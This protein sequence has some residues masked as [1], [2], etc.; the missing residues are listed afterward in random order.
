[1]AQ[2]LNLEVSFNKLFLPIYSL[3]IAYSYNNKVPL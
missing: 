3:G 1:M 2:F